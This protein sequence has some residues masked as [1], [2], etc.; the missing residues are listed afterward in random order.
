MASELDPSRP[1]S[2]APEPGGAL[3]FTLTAEDVVAAYRLQNWARLLSWASLISLVFSLSVIAGL[4]AVAMPEAPFVWKA[5]LVGGALAGG[6]LLP[7]G[8]MRWRVPALA[9]RIHRQQRGLREEIMLEWTSEALA[10]RSPLGHGR[11]LWT[12]YVRWREDRAI[13]LLFQS[14]AIFQM[15]PKRILPPPVL[16]ALRSYAA[17]ANVKGAARPRA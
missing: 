2:S 11:L 14:D 9:R 10:A 16:E 1:T 12:D 17:A 4:V 6:L 13:V 3:S 8:M 7:L 15:L 5:A